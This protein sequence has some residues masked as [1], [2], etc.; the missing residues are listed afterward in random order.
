M[1]KNYDVIIVGGGVVG[2][3]T[4]YAMS[5]YSNFKDVLLLEKE[6]D[7]ALLNSNSNNNSQTLHSGEIETNYSIEKTK[8]TKENAQ[9]IVKYAEKELEPDER[10]NIIQQCQKMA[11]AVGDEEVEKL[12]KRYDSD[13]KEIFPYVK[14]IDKKD[15]LEK[16]EPNIIKGRDPNQKLLALFT[17][18]GYMVDYHNLSKSFLDKALLKEGYNALFQTEVKDIKKTPEGYIISAKN[19]KFTARSVLVTA[20]AYSLYFAKNLGY[21]MDFGVLSV[22]GK[23]YYSKK[24]LNGKVYRVE[25]EG[26]PFAAVH[27][28]PDITNPDITRFGP[29]VNI[30]PEL[31]KGNLKSMPD[32]LKSLNLDL[33][34]I[35][36]L[37]KILFDETI[38]KIVREN[39]VY[40]IPSIGKIYFT[41]NEVNKIVPSLKPNDLKLAENVGGIRPQ[42]IDTKKKQLAL[43]GTAIEGDGA[44]FSVTPSPGATSCLKEAMDN[45]LY[46]ADYTENE[47]YLE[48]FKKYF[49]YK[50]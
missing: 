28:D 20:G 32:Y 24:V 36:S 11:L 46:L 39:F 49:E 29:T 16:V 8:E 48:D 21:G 9:L 10:P 2:T 13:F 19:K 33:D 35:E 34:T 7:V 45:C 12:E 1:E 25:R 4:M 50:L 27:G 41:R 23:F 18:N 30:Y 17:E 43:G 3:A 42:I 26:I 40:S 14:K 15:E 37:E 6:K 44:L 47:F 5:R 22:G 31:E 38:S